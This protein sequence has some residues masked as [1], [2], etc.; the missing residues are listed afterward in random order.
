[1]IHILKKLNLKIF[2][3]HG[4]IRVGI[5]QNIL[6][7]VFRRQEYI[8]PQNFLQYR[9]LDIFKSLLFHCNSDIQI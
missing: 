6:F 2:N 7:Q 8:S 9:E 3:H 1:M 4:L 5:D